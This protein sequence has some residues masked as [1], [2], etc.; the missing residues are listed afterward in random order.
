ME[1]IFSLAV[2]VM[3]FRERVTGRE[4]VGIALLSVSILA[5]GLLG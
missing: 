3:V 5:I 4:I 1:L 2:S